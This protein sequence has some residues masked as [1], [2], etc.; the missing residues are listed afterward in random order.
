MFLQ[1]F[2]SLGTNIQQV[3]QIKQKK[4]NG[5]FMPLRR[6][7]RQTANK[8]IRFM[9]ND[10]P[11]DMVWLG[12]GTNNNTKKNKCLRELHHP[13]TTTTTWLKPGNDCGHDFKWHWLLVGNRKWTAVSCVKATHQS[14]STS[15][16]CWLCPSIIT[17]PD[18]LCSHHT[19]VTLWCNEVFFFTSQL[20]YQSKQTITD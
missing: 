12:A 10:S 3:L 1:F 13:I 11:M 14:S 15:C 18:L 16:L 4:T 8:W 6:K 17:S 2:T 5:L 7:H 20:T 9:I 19:N